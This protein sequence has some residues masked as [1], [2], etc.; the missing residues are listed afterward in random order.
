MKAN[1]IKRVLGSWIFVLILV[2]T[3]NALTDYDT[4]NGTAI[5][6]SKWENQ[7]FIREIRSNKLFSR[8]RA[9]ASTQNNHLYVKTPGGI[10]NLEAAVTLINATAPHDAIQTTTAS[11]GLAGVFYN[12]GTVGSGS[13]G[14]VM[15]Q[16]RLEG[17]SGQLRARYYVIRYTAADSSTWDTLDSGTIIP[18]ISLNTAYTL[19]IRFDQGSKKFTFTAGP[20]ASYETPTMPGTLNAPKSDWKSLRTYVQAPEGFVGNVAAYFT[21]AKTRNASN[22]IVMF[23]ALNVAPISSSNWKENYEFAREIVSD[24]L[25]LKMRRVDLTSATGNTL[26]FKRPEMI[27]EIEGKVSLTLFQKSLTESNLQARIGGYFYNSEGNPASNYLGEIYAGIFLGGSDASPKAGWYVNRST[28]AAGTTFETL[29]PLTPTPLVSPINLG[30]T[31][32]LY[33]KW[34]GVQFTAKCTD[35]VGTVYTDTFAPGTGVY[36]SNIH[37]KDLT[38]RIWPPS[39]PVANDSTVEATFDNVMTNIEQLYLPLILNN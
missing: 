8:V 4:F 38:V 19:S 34:D 3:A 23:D 16:V 24:H 15:A 13:V 6:Y 5:N 21:D 22:A 32:T 28:N 17:S 10:Y 9:Y 26:P 2:T 12:D 11:A 1:K 33:L 29:Y 20:T 14:D 35:S 27:N 31:Y 39:S 37:Y 18:S 7:E 30:E 36:P 25:H